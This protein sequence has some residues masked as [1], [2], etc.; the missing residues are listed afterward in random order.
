MSLSGI[1]E[2]HLVDQSTAFFDKRIE[3]P[4]A[5]FYLKLFGWIRYMKLK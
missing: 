1:F 4:A 3:A 5:D 2:A